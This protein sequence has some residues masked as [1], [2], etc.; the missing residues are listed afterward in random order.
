MRTL[1]R[2]ALGILSGLAVWQLLPGLTA[3]LIAAGALG[4]VGVVV[5]LRSRQDAR[6]RATGL[7]L[8]LALLSGSALPAVDRG[9]PQVGHTVE[10][11]S[12]EIGYWGWLGLALLGGLLYDG[13]K[14]LAGEWWDQDGVGH[15][16]P[17]G[18]NCSEA[19]PCLEAPN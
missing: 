19:W 8:T 10:V 9:A 1:L 5:F 17:A 15:P 14:W 4:V 2:P 7:L 13:A 18:A 16:Y 3:K 11:Q 6:R 12:A